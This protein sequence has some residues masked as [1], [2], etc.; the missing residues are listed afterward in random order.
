MIPAGFT[1]DF[2]DDSAVDTKDAPLR[3][4]QSGYS[5]GYNSGTSGQG[6]PTIINSGTCASHG[7]AHYT[8]GAA[9]VSA[10]GMLGKPT[11]SQH[12]SP[13]IASGQQDPQGCS[14]E[15]G[16]IPT[17]NPRSYGGTCDRSQWECICDCSSGYNSGYNSGGAPTTAPTTAPT[18]SPIAATPTAT[19][20]AAGAPQVI[21]TIFQEVKLT[22]TMSDFN[23]PKMQ[24]L[25]KNGYAIGINCWD[26][27]TKAIK[28]VC[29]IQI[30]AMRRSTIT[31]TYTS[32]ITDEALGK[33]ALTSSK[34]LTKA[35]LTTHLNT[36]KAADTS[37]ASVVVPTVSEI[38]QPTS[39]T[40]TVVSGARTTAA[41]SAAAL[42]FAMLSL[43]RC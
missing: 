24:T 39:K 28:S 2:G 16:N 15:M 1:A 30:S 19:P 22:M 6:Q 20:T 3:R 32:R 4:Y 14:I 7:C 34:A 9:C 25:L 27:N 38:K 5:S 35:T 42:G 43:L 21:T 40:E 17:F 36:A 11:S 18:P 41:F 31:V 12:G 26:Y 8:S 13:H 23:M 10:L 37:L 33:T 29:T